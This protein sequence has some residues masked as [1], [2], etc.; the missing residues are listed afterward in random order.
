MSSKNHLGEVTA[1]D[2]INPINMHRKIDENIDGRMPID[3]ANDKVM[4][5]EGD[6]NV[7]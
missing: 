4:M 1:A 7:G 5:Q 3:D 6:T 2:D